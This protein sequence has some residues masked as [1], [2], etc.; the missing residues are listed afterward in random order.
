M[1]KID[2]SKLSP[3]ECWG[4][5]INGTKHCTNCKWTG[6]SACEGKNI[7]RTGHNSLG[8]RIGE[9]GIIQEEYNP[10]FDTRLVVVKHEY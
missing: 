7:V 5:Q 3:D 1:K 8:Y 2:T 9:N 10:D 4:I 6:I